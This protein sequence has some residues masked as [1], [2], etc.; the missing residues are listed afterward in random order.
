MSDPTNPWAGCGQGSESRVWKRLDELKEMITTLL[1]VQ[2]ER[3]KN[4]QRHD[5][6][7]NKLK[8]QV[9]S[10]ELSRAE[11]RG[12]AMIL[13]VVASALTS[14]SVSVIGGLIIWHWKG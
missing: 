4:C 13:A 8:D 9:H 6:C 5:V 11:S 1:A 10:L 7:L 3:E 14:V 2:G 12:K